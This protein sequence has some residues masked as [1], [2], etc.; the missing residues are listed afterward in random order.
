VTLNLSSPLADH[1][2]AYYNGQDDSANVSITINGDFPT[3]AEAPT[4]DFSI[5]ALDGTVY[6][7]MEFYMGACFSRELSHSEIKRLHN[8]GMA[9]V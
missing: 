1:F 9:L 2:K 5:G 7:T 6:N 4:I 8:F 3:L